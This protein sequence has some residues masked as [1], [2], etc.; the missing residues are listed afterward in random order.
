MCGWMSA[1]LYV[2]SSVGVDESVEFERCVYEPQSK[3]KQDTKNLGPLVYVVAFYLVGRG[4]LW[5]ES[6][7]PTVIRL[8]AF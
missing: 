4:K 8:E 5:F 7:N 3:Q 1:W 6:L 2:C